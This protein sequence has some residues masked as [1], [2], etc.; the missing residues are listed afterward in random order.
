[1]PRYGRNGSRARKRRRARERFCYTHGVEAGGRVVAGKYRIEGVVGEGGMGTVVLATHLGLGQR[2]A[3]KLLR[4]RD[5]SLATRLAREAR[6][7]AELRG[8]HVA[9]MLDA[10]IL[11]DGAPYLAMELLAGRDLGAYLV[12][13][14]PLSVGEACA[15]ILHACEGLAE[16]HARGIVHR[17]LKPRNLFRTHRV[18]GRPIVK[19][20]DFGIAKRLDPGVLAGSGVLTRAGDIVGSPAYM[21]PESLKGFPQSDARADVWSLGVVAYELLTTRLPFDAPSV[22]A[23]AAMVHEPLAVPLASARP[24]APPA[25]VAAVMA[26]LVADPMRRMPDVAAL[27]AELA[28]FASLDYGD[29][30]NAPARLRAILS[31]STTPTYRT[32]SVPPSASPEDFRPTQSFQA[33][34]VDARPKA[35]EKGRGALVA[36]IVFGGALLASLT[37]AALTLRHEPNDQGPTTLG[38]TAAGV[39]PSAAVTAASEAPRPMA[40]SASP[41]PASPTS[42]VAPAPATP[43]V[44]PSA[45]NAPPATPAAD[46]AGVR[47]LA[48]EAKGPLGV[49]MFRPHLSLA[50]AQRCYAPFLAQ[51]PTIEG[52][53]VYS[54]SV[55]PDGTLE[56]TSAGGTLD[57]ATK[58]CLLKVLD[59]VVYPR[60]NGRTEV[61]WILQI[62][63]ASAPR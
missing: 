34:E 48:L 35:T 3:L 36:G 9:R 51:N 20:L 59:R 8:E 16:A 13:R 6:A 4:T 32:N 2:V 5:P 25:V 52:R 58:D 39:H 29:V 46:W 1:V 37:M 38:A 27:A 31:S 26:C 11:E 54:T 42:P 28:P 56:H 21:A 12:E 23:L 30:R 40:P 10:G 19:V 18:D 33:A 24:D 41:K 60:S 14:G 44:R 47:E 45:S 7:V 57:G 62:R 22:G 53:Y 43:K 15:C 50:L 55:L 61:T 49:A 63:G 17:D